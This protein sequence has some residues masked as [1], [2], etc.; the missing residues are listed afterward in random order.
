[1]IGQAAA[2]VEAEPEGR[3]AIC[4]VFEQI[5]SL[6]ITMAESLGK[7]EEAREKAVVLETV[8]RD[9]QPV[10]RRWR[11]TVTT[12]LEAGTITAD[13]IV[14]IEESGVECGASAS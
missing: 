3:D 9:L 2:I 12:M 7:A 1:M 6:S 5:R 8:S 10:V 14:L 13:W 4:G 11:Q